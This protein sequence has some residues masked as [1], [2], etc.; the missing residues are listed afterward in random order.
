MDIAPLFGISLTS[1]SIPSTILVYWRTS[2]VG[3]YKVNT[4]EYV[5]DRFASGC[6]IIRDSSGQCVHTFFSSYGECSILEADFK[7]I[8]AQKIGLSDLWIE[9]DSTLAIHCIIR[10]GGPWSIQATLSHI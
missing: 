6:G 9:S 2:L 1:P 4:D 7:T 10:G 5:K 3:S 8:L